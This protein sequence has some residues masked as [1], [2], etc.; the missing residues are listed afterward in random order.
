MPL[1]RR[2]GRFASPLVLA[3][4]LVLPACSSDDPVSPAQVCDAASADTPVNLGALQG[5]RVSYEDADRCASLTGA[6]ARYLVVPQFATQFRE[7]SET[8][9]FVGNSGTGVAARLAARTAGAGPLRTARH[10]TAQSRLDARLRALEGTMAKEAALLA[11]QREAAGQARLERLD[12]AT[13]NQFTTTRTFKTLANVFG[14]SFETVTATLKFQG[15]NIVIYVDNES[16]TGFTDEAIAALG[17]LFDQ[18]LYPIGS[19]AFGSESDIDSNGRIIVLMTPKVNA[20]VNAGEC[21][22]QGFITGYFF[23]F[24]LASTGT[25]SNRGEVFY[26]LVPDPS[27]Q[28]SC[29]HAV[30]DVEQIVPATFIHELQHMI[31]YNQ[32]VLVRNGDEEDVWL[33]EGLSLIAEE[34]ASR[35]YEDRYPPPTG[36]T[37]PEQLFPDSAQGFITNNLIYAY[38]YLKESPDVSVTTFESSGTLEERGAAFLFLRWLLDQKGPGLARQLVQSNLTGIQNVSVKAGEPFEALFGDFAVAVYTDSLPGVARDAIPQRYR[39]TS[40]NLR[41]LFARLHQIGAVG[42]QPFPIVPATLPAEGGV[43]SAMVQG[44]MQHYL[45]QSGES[46]VPMH[47]VRPDKRG[48]DADLSPQVSIFRLP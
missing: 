36:R 27:G 34:L 40:R 19:G 42:P 14:T 7:P 47:L 48:L 31:S 24:D 26:T 28:F 9:Y 20:L 22:E 38:N 12:G 21:A 15:T 16:P 23:G 45:L 44:T 6:G 46:A 18:T 13:V 43:T 17:P 32:H 5:T 4:A 10:S 1:V 41:R 3:L 11:R 37:N 25:N 35:Y 8:D 29:A 30:D 2:T 39:F 33:N